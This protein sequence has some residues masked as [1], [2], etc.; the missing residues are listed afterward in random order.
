MK[1]GRRILPYLTADESA[2]T[3][4]SWWF[5]RAGTRLPLPKYLPAWDY[6]S[7]LAVGLTATINSDL[8]LASTGL[9]TLDQ[10]ALVLVGDCKASQRR[11]TSS[12][13]LFPGC[14]VVDVGL[15]VPPGQVAD[16]MDLCATLVLAEDVE[17]AVDR[18]Q[19]AGSRLASSPSHS[20]ILE[21]DASR[22]PTEPISFS[23]A[24]YEAAPWTISST[25]E[26]LEDSLMGS[27]RL[28]INED[29]PWGQQLLADAS[30]DVSKQLHVDVFRS[31]VIIC[32]DLGEHPTADLEED[33][34]G[35]VVDYMCQLYLRRGLDEAVKVIREEPLRFDR[36][37]YSA[38]T[39]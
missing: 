12:V 30:A 28:L 18:V 10:L 15:T 33:S 26:S 37:V 8:V 1:R 5:E 17:P 32:A 6:A 39:P 16:S 27:V 23:A 7:D 22:F 20:L 34:L 31:L 24:G 29:H 9:E 21:G 3:W 25:A 36:L 2:V 35:G 19:R 14:E 13:R 11:F 38:V 4:E